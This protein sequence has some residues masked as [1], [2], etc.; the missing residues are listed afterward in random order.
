MI[1]NSEQT[2]HTCAMNSHLRLDSAL[3]MHHSAAGSDNVIPGSQKVR[4]NH[5]PGWEKALQKRLAD[6]TTHRLAHPGPCS[7]RDRLCSQGKH[8]APL[9]TIRL[10]GTDHC[11]PTRQRLTPGV[12]GT[13]H[14]TDQ[15]MS[16]PGRYPTEY[17]DTPLNS[18]PMDQVSSLRRV[19]ILKGRHNHNSNSEKGPLHGTDSA[20]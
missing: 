17:E 13:T 12:A 9:E 2:R 4:G 20:N 15:P 16:K 3:P 19:M 14:L 10:P 11:S 5:L 18:A 7:Q 6:R 1:P 8:D